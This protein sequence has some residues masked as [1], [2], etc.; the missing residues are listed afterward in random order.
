M[1]GYEPL[2]G[3]ILVPIE[4]STQKWVTPHAFTLARATGGELIFLHVLPHPPGEDQGPPSFL[5]K[6]LDGAARLDL[7]ASYMLRTGSVVETICK[8]AHHIQADLIILVS[9]AKSN[10]IERIHREL[11]LHKHPL[12]SP[13]PI[14]VVPNTEPRPQGLSSVPPRRHTY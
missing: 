8:M 14:L 1:K 7:H 2:Y 5:R 4:E 3:K 12:A 13:C 11:F 10:R 9:R 6:I